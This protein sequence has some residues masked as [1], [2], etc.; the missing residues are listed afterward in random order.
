[1]QFK[2][3]RIGYATSGCILIGVPS[4]LLALRN[5][6]YTLQRM[7]LSTSSTAVIFTLI[8]Q[9]LPSI[10]KNKTSIFIIG[11]FFFW[12][13]KMLE[14]AFYGDKYFQKRN[15]LKYWQVILHSNT[16]S[17]I[18]FNEF[19]NNEISTRKQS[20]YQLFEFSLYGALM[21]G[22]KTILS[23][24][25]VDVKSISFPVKVSILGIT[26][27]STLP[28]QTGLIPSIIGLV[29]GNRIKIKY[30]YETPL[31][32]INLKS[33]WKRWSV[34]IGDSL[35][36]LIYKPLYGGNIG[37]IALFTVNMLDH[38]CLSYMVRQKTQYIKGWSMAFATM[39]IG[40]IIDL[41]LNVYEKKRKQSKIIGYIRYALFIGTS[42]IALSLAYGTAF[43]EPTM[44]TSKKGKT[45]I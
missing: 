3:S 21:Y 1:M 7:I 31:L 12:K 11:N 14:I 26:L 27:L 32:S 19:K 8:T 40:T 45:N 37:V 39:G 5:D 35:K 20:I 18:T 15:I 42:M 38:Y 17:T 23:N 10:K 34:Q 2:D 29:L 25:K 33:F 36:N 9:Y 24:P 43:D 6:K 30:S 16:S 44:L 13:W 4:L 28:I 41:K 22:I